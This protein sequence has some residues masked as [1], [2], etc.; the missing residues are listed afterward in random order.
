MRLRHIEPL[1]CSE[2]CVVFCLASFRKILDHIQ[3]RKCYRF[4]LIEDIRCNQCYIVSA[5]R[6]LVTPY[7]YFLQVLG[8]NIYRSFHYPNVGIS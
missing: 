2:C 8:S 1:Q 3:R 6:R 7:T 4:P 5:K